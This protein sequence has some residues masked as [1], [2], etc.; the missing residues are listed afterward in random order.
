V[1]IVVARASPVVLRF[2]RPV[3][4][5]RGQFGARRS[6]LLELRDDADRPGFGEAAPWPGFGTESF[7][8]ALAALQGLVREIAGATFA[9][10]ASWSD[11][12]A[13]LRGT[14]AAQ[15]ALAGALLDLEAR[16]AGVPLAELLARRFSPLP[17]PTLTSVPVSA[18]FRARDPGALRD[19]AARARADGFRVAKLKLA[20]G[21]LAEDLGRVQAA[22]E[23][24]GDGTTLRGDANGAWTRDEAGLALEALADF[25]FEYVEQPLP[26]EDVEGL[27]M[28]RRQGAMRIAADESLA[29]VDGV[30]K[31]L[32]AA[33]VDVFVLK[34][35]ALG[36][37][38]KALAVASAARDAGIDCVFTH[39]FDSAVGARHVLHCAA[40]W[41]NPDVA[42][43][44]ATAGLFTDD[45]ASPVTASDGRVALSM[46]PGLGIT[47]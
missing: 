20:A 19:E 3:V 39:A 30:R 28:L 12:I 43:G 21:S 27:A 45:V 8:A 13:R 32:D 38:G 17:G 40:A 41:G 18:L 36:G 4:T 46:G 42:H 2:A 34:P 35:S 7:E 5:S 9:S 15:G 31:L 6:V 26:A 11:T 10:E 14:P 24:F 23:G 25:G 29:T 33:A 37:A 47:P 22:R 16:R 1:K 44:L